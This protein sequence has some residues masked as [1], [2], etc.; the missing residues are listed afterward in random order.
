M[1]T[2]SVYYHSVSVYYHRMSVPGQT[3]LIGG[4]HTCTNKSTNTYSLWSVKP[5]TLFSAT[6]GFGNAINE[7]FVDFIPQLGW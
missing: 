7:E 5:A 2:I 6:G 1:S 3:I 4:T